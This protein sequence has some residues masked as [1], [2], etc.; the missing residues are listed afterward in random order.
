MDIRVEITNQFTQVAEEQ[1]RKIAPLTDNLQLLE[2]GLDSLS[3]AI[4]VARLEDT[5]GVDPF[6]VSDDAVFPVT[7]GDLVGLYENAAKQPQ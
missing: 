1:G 5:L 3:F 6:S 4:V 7:F 2:S